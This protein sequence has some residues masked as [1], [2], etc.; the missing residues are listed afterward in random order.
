VLNGVRDR[1]QHL[2]AT[3]THEA[4]GAGQTLKAV[5]GLLGLFAASVYVV[6]GLVLSLR[7][8]LREL[9]STAVV[10]QLPREFL[11]SSGL[12]TVGPPVV[13]G[14]LAYVLLPVRWRTGERR[15]RTL[16]LLFAAIVAVTV[17]VGALW[18]AK[19]PFVAK[20]CMTAGAPVSGFFIGEA[21]ERT[22]LGENGH[23]PRRIVSLPSGQVQRLLIGGAA[24]GARCR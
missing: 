20:A 12:L 6:G 4:E 23:T 24:A 2:V 19:A 17:I 13:A 18:V 22:Y 16:R 5:A 3:V 10:S 14:G 1:W 21:K 9:P 11:V 8:G 7:L 15:T